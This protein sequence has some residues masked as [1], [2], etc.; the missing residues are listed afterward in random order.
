MKEKIGLSNQIKITVRN[1]DGSVKEVKILK[2]QIKNGWLNAFRDAMLGVDIDFEVKYLSWGSSNV[3]NDR[4]QTQL[5]AEFGRKQV[6]SRSATGTGEILTT[7]YISPQEAV[8]ET[9]EELAWWAGD[10]TDTPN[11]GLMIGRIL[12]HRDKTN[13]ESIEIERTDTISEVI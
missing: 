13:L 5:G 11:S 7:V 9:I 4:A 10:A 3:V 8:E 1:L 6:T 2:N 12:Y